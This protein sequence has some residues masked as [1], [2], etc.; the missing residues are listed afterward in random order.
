MKKYT[1]LAPTHLKAT[2]TER[3]L[4][5]AMAIQT[6]LRAGELRSLK[7]GKVFFG[8]SPF[9]LIVGS[10]T[11]DSKDARQY[12][13][14]DLANEIEQHV[15]GK[16]K[17]DQVFSFNRHSRWSTII[18]RDLAFARS[19]WLEEAKADPDESRRRMES[20]LLLPTNE[21]GEVLVFHSLR[22][23]CGAW[24]AQA[25]AHPKEIQ[26][27]MR[28]STITLT[29]DTY[30]HLFP[31]QNK[32]TVTLLNNFMVNTSAYSASANS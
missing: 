12:I 5:Y 11:K 1:K 7:V 10:S 15:Q 8:E 26:S 18:Q 9:V 31:D 14:P 30:G 13:L 27:I 3:S 22:H 6:G 16:K 28:H 23:T 24:L 20:D 2:G 32:N 21:E 4:L 25:G 19:K 17:G 29:M